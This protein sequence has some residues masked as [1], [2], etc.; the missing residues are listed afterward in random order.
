MRFS[1]FLEYGTDIGRGWFIRDYSWF[2]RLVWIDGLARC[3]FQNRDRLRGCRRLGQVL[4]K[5]PT[6]DRETQHSEH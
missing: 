1:W 3:S 6:S 4:V 5:R 2:W